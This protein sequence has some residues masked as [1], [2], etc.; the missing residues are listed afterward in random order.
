MGGRS[1]RSVMLKAKNAPEH[2][3]KVH[4]NAIDVNQ[5]NRRI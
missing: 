3:P 2:I 1:L 4:R 5:S